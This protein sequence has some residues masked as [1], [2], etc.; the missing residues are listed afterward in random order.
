[1]ST[2]FSLSSCGGIFRSWRKTSPTSFSTSEIRSA[3]KSTLKNFETRFHLGLAFLEQGLIEE[4][5]EEFLLASEDA[6]RTL[7]CYSI[8]SKAYRRIGDFEE[9]FKWLRECLKLAKEG[10]SEFYA[11]EYE[12]ASLYEEKGDLPKAIEHYLRIKEWNPGYQDV[13]KKVKSLA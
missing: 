9:A 6:S 12:L 1:M 10:T 3:G 8:I 4:A 13:G 7:E 11:L 2:M 5:V